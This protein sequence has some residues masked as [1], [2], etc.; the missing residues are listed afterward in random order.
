MDEYNQLIP[1]VVDRTPFGERAYDIYS[2]L[3][4]ER[5][6]F[7]GGP[8]NDAVA[9][10]IIAQFLYLQHSNPN[11][12]I[13]FYI[14]SPGGVISSTLAIYDTMQLVR[15]QVETICIGMAASGAA[16][17]LSS[18][19][20][21]KRYALPNAEIMLHQPMING[22]GGVEGQASDI[23]IAAKHIARLKAQLNKILAENSNQP[24]EKVE[25]DTDRDFYMT[26]EEAKAYGLID[27]IITQSREEKTEKEKKQIVRPK[28][29]LIKNLN[30]EPRLVN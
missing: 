4:Q 20:K 2:R 14:N 22:G 8:I 21:G 10:T 6:I 1:I 11:K 17:L 28:H 3:L 23:E 29:R 7:L 27:E 24:F 18:G 5:I 9:N 30:Q 19:A 26:A 12:E 13:K 16:V 25:R 15:P